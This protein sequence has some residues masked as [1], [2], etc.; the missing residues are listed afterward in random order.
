MKPR[1][2]LPQECGGFLEEAEPVVELVVAD[3]ARVIAQRVHRGD[4]RV[5]VAVL[6]ATLV[7]VRC[8]QT[9]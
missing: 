9:S 2:P 3:G 7:G 6:H 8:L 5:H 1:L 4:D